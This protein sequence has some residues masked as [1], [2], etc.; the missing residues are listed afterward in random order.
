MDNLPG[1]PP[2]RHNPEFVNAGDSAY[3]AIFRESVFAA[4]IRAPQAGLIARIGAQG[5]GRKGPLHAGHLRG[6]F[7]EGFVQPP[8]RFVFF[9]YTV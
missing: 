5:F 8:E 6:M 1:G 2:T 7:S 4:E 3:G 9:P